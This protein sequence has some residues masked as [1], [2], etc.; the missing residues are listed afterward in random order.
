[1]WLDVRWRRRTDVPHLLEHRVVAFIVP[2]PG[3]RS[4]SVPM[5][6]SRSRR[7]RPI[8]SCSDRRSL[9]GVGTPRGCCGFVGHHRRGTISANDKLA[10]PQ[11]FSIDWLGLDAQHRTWVCDPRR[12][13]SYLSYGQPVIAAAN[14]TVVDAPDGLPDQHPP[15]APPVPQIKDTVGNH[16]IVR[17]G[18]GLFCS[19]GILNTAGCGCA[20]ASGCAAPTV[21]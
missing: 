12:L 18:R 3:A 16:V 9:R 15:H 6:S 13:S 20:G 1:M 5:F 21:G 2:P 8:R 4:I 10:V 7:L 11:R 17:V 14:G 19:T